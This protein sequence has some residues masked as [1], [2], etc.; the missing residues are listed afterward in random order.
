MIFTYFVPFYNRD[1]VFIVSKNFLWQHYPKEYWYSDLC[2]NKASSC[3]APT[4]SLLFFKCFCF[5][6]QRFHYTL[7]YNTSPIVYSWASWALEKYFNKG[8]SGA[9]VYLFVLLVPSRALRTH[10]PSSAMSK[11]LPR[12]SVHQFTFSKIVLLKSLLL[13]LHKVIRSRLYMAPY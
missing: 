1:K 7:H 2:W 9:F 12:S 10:K 8:R 3:T 13:G 5:L 11:G 6:W 4:G